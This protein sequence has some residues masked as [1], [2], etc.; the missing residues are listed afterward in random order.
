MFDQDRAIRLYTDTISKPDSNTARFSLGNLIDRMLFSAPCIAKVSK[1]R[2]FPTKLFDRCSPIAKL[3][4]LAVV[5]FC[6]I[7][8]AFDP[9]QK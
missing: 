4:A 1:K 8:Y 7:P 9:V 6:L 3:G 2:I 5:R